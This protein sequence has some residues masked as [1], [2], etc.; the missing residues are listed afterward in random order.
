MSKSNHPIMRWRLCQC[1]VNGLVRPTNGPVRI[2]STDI[3][4]DDVLKARLSG[5][6]GG[7]AATVKVAGRFF[8]VAPKKAGENRI[9]EVPADSLT[10]ALH[11]GVFM[12]NEELKRQKKLPHKKRPMPHVPVGKINKAAK[13]RKKR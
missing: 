7:T 12:V 9:R 1:E 2:K 3:V 10:D 5:P 13:A 11:A 8:Y 6:Q 4:A